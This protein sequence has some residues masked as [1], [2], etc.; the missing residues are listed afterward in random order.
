M[1]LTGR[2]HRQGATTINRVRTGITVGAVLIAGALGGCGSSD[3]DKLSSDV[4]NDFIAG[5][6]Q[7]GQ[8]KDGCECLYTELTETQGIDTEGELKKLNDQ[9]Q[10]AVKSPNPASAL[11]ESFK[12]AAVACKDKLQG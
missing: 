7:G 10:E 8:S 2:V 1:L 3:D 9:V 5:C 12:K 11:P 6:Q 4:K